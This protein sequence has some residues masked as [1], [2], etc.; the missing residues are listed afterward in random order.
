LPAQ[1]VAV[2][3]GSVGGTSGLT[4]FD[5][6]S[7][8]N[9]TSPDGS[10]FGNVTGVSIAKDGTMTALF[11]NGLSQSVYKIPIATFTNANGLGQVNGN[12]YVATRESGAA[13]VNLAGTGRCW[14]HC[15]PL[16]EASTVI[17]RR[18]HNL[19][20]TQ[21][22][23]SASARIITTAN[24]IQQLEQLPTNKVNGKAH[25]KAFPAPAEF[26]EAFMSL[27]TTCLGP[28]KRGAAYFSADGVGSFKWKSARTRELRHRPDGSPL[29]LADLPPPSTRRW[30]IRRK[31]EVVAAVADC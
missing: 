16:L 4:Q 21:R 17:W 31:A 19:I 20:T 3:L 18:V 15:R 28:F 6:A 26:N 5:T 2:N 23:Y 10:S 13:S 12:A 24:Q 1:A 11:S 29:T 22:A 27:F 30:V 9:G 14:R 8:L 25:E 7:T